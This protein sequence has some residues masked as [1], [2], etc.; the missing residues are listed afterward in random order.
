M[1]IQFYDREE[2]LKVIENEIKSPKASLIIIFGRRRIGK[3][4][5]VLKALENFKHNYIYVENQNVNNFFG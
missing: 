1:S 4:T 5:L 3:T 2:E